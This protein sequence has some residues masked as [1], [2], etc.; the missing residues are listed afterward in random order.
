MIDVDCGDC[1]QCC[2]WG[3]AIRLIPDH[4]LIRADE[5][6]DCIHLCEEGCSLYGTED[7]PGVCE[8]FSCAQ[9]VEDMT[10]DPLMKVLIE[11]VKRTHDKSKE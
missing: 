10:I 7:R 1:R 8:R 2:K 4:P 5:N 6:G 3:S 9:L 11:G